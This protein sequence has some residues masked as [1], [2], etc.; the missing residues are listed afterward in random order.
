[1]QI[2]P[3]PTHYQSVYTNFDISSF[4]LISCCAKACKLQAYLNALIAK[5]GWKSEEKEQA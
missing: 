2:I 4:S 1:M 5:K 3:F